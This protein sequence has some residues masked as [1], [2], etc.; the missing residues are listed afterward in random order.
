MKS[1]LSSN[2][3]AAA[4]AR[5]A[6]APTSGPVQ[7]SRS[8]L[9]MGATASPPT[10]AEISALGAETVRGDERIAAR[11]QRGAGLSCGKPMIIR[12]IAAAPQSAGSGLE[13]VL[14]VVGELVDRFLDVGERGVR[15]R[16]P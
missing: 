5:H 14:P 15:L 13:E 1:S 9:R 16:L 3:S 11:R 2:A 8:V 12:R 4:C 6:R 7:R 10:C